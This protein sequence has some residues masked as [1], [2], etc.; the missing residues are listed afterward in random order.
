MTSKDYSLNNF[1]GNEYLAYMGLSIGEGRTVI[2]AYVDIEIF[3]LWLTT[4]FNN[5][6]IAEGAL[7]WLKRYGHLLSP[8]KIRRLANSGVCYNQQV[9]NGIVNFME[10]QNIKYN[11]F[12]ILKTPKIRK[13]LD[14]G[15]G[16]RIRNPMKEFEIENVL[17]P[18]FNLDDNKF[19]KD[20]KS[21]LEK[22]LELRSR[23]LFG[24]CLNADIF[25]ILKKHPKTSRYEIHKITTHHKKSINDVFRG[26]SLAAEYF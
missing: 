8:S 18:N 17:I 5:S 7:C 20:E 13:T 2:N 21:V 4:Q 6:R 11:Q 3:F 10:N 14:F 25:S 9:L 15:H 24:S 1:N 26:A 16:V 23:M 19:L 12:K 22:N